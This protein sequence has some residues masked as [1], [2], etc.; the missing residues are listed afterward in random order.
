MK[1]LLLLFLF[2]FG[3][4]EKNLLDELENE[5]YEYEEV[6]VVI[7]QE[8]LNSFDI[9]KEEYE[10]FLGLKTLVVYEQKEIYVFYNGNDAL[11][12]KLKERNNEGF[13]FVD[14]DDYV[15][16]GVNDLKIIDLVKETLNK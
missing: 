5:I 7:N 10:D 2:V 15:Y 8:E 16:Y 13:V 1:I 11:K 6:Y 4:K 12:A 3:C 14:M 9:Q